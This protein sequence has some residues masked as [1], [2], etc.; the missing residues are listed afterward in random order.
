VPQHLPEEA[1]PWL[2]AVLER[3]E[4][5]WQRG[6]DPD[7]GAFLANHAGAARE[8][9][10]VELVHEDLDY[11]LRAGQTARVE[12]YL[13]RFPELG[14]RQEVLLDLLASE[15]VLREAGG[16]AV[17]PDEYRARFPALAD[18][19][20]ARVEALRS[21]AGGPSPG[22]LAIPH[23][24]PAEQPTLDATSP[25]AVGDLTQSPEAGVDS[26]AGEGPR[27]FG[28]YELLGEIARGAMGVVYKAR[29]AKLNR[30][31]ALKMILAGQLAS[32][33]E[34]RRFYTEAEA[35]ATLDHPGIVPIY[36]IAQHQGQHYFSMAFV[37]GHSLAEALRDGPLAPRAAADLVR[38][39]ALAV[40][41]A[42]DKG[43]IHRDLK[44]QNV[45]L[46]RSGQPRVTDFGLAR[47][48]GDGQLTATGAVVG[49][50]SYMPPEQAAGR[51]DVGP[52]A[53]VYALGAILYCL[54]TG[55]PPFQAATTLDTLL[56]VLEQEPVPPRRHNPQVPADLETICLAC[57]HKQPARR[58]SS[59]RALADDLGRW[60]EGRPILARPVGRLERAWK[61]ARRRPAA[62]ALAALS[63]LAPVLLLLVG[64]VYQVR[65]GQA[66][67]DLA[68]RQQDLEVAQAETAAAGD[69]ANRLLVHAG[70]LRLSALSSL[71]L[72]DNAGL[73]LLLAVEGAERGRPREAA[74]N[75]ALVAALE[76]NREVQ[77]FGT[78]GWECQSAALSED[79]RRLAVSAGM[80]LRLWDI[81]DPWS[82]RRVWKADPF[83]WHGPTPILLS[84]DGRWVARRYEGYMQS[85]YADGSKVLYTDRVVRVWDTTAGG[86]G[87]WLL[88][89]H[90]DRVSAAAFSPDGRHLLTGSWDGTARLWDLATGKTTAV[91]AGHANSLAA[92]LFTPDGRQAL[93]VS[94]RFRLISHLPDDFKPDVLDPPEYRTDASSTGTTPGSVEG[95][96]PLPEGGVFAR[97]W[98]LPGGRERVAFAWSEGRPPANP[99]RPTS[100]AFSGDGG[101]VAFGFEEGRHRAGVWEAATGRLI[102]LVDV[103]W[104]VHQVALSRDGRRLLAASPSRWQVWDV[105]AG[106]P[107]GGQQARASWSW[108]AVRPDGRQVAAAEGDFVRVWDSDTG[109]EDFELRGHQASVHFLA[110]GQDGRRVVTAGENSA[111]LWDATPNFSPLHALRLDRGSARDA[112]YSPDGKRVVASTTRKDAVL[113]DP[114][115]GTRTPLRP[116]RNLGVLPLPDEMFGEVNQVAFS[117]DGRRVLTLAA[118][119]PA[120]LSLNPSLGGL[121]RPHYAEVPH[122]PV[123][124]WDA[125][126]GKL[127][128]TLAGH[129]DR[130]KEAHFS[131]DGSRILT[132]SE[133]RDPNWRAEFMP[134]GRRTGQDA[135]PPDVMGRVWDAATGKEVAAF[136]GAPGT[137]PWSRTA[138]LSPDGTR[139]FVAGPGRVSLLDAATCRE[140]WSATTVSP[141]FTF[142]EFSDD[143]QQILAVNDS[144]VSSSWLTEGQ[145]LYSWDAAT[146]KMASTERENSHLTAAHF[147]PGTH[148]VLWALNTGRWRLADLDGGRVLLSREAHSRAVRLEFST[149]GRH[150]VTVSEDGTTRV[151]DAGSGAEVLT[152]GESPSSVR[153]A[154]FRPDGGALLTVAEDGVVR[155]VPID[156]LPVAR[157]H[158]PR[159]LTAQERER[160]GV[161]DLPAAPAE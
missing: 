53:D 98:D 81:S 24:S 137:A 5:A 144:N 146:G 122:R 82:P 69:R 124:L 45:L 94:H 113:W 125:A 105:Q 123:R 132:L 67:A 54:L 71:V 47:R 84:P 83:P 61:W 91:L 100:A 39:V 90:R 26:P 8:A 14:Q 86:R 99:F 49:T 37:E 9:L 121:L 160:Y 72:Q 55:H 57:L 159:A 3:F 56:L 148:Q 119:E 87:R 111:R 32:P 74:H 50:P 118:D 102:R 34:V 129:T 59:A 85:R 114:A 157:A 4:T 142:A 13:A 17:G 107:L 156:P 41:H 7:L 46:D 109:E 117:P 6:E 12:A 112:V 138:A 44:P 70:G 48:A 143:G 11:R 155:V 22:R 116:E 92:A 150:F 139:L 80:D 101:E 128:L 42:H 1:W 25:V 130:V 73:A 153:R 2:E 66:R 35:A 97:L 154:H 75:S 62:A 40:Q 103:E 31:V 76:Q 52:A 106:R 152:L 15:Y 141:A 20:P 68:R 78:P 18:A 51:K 27:S 29:Q 23:E 30:V 126:T 63:V 145:R 140:R 77:T 43:I 10:L 79:G 110:Y 19:M 93:T 16:E 36:E 58:Y 108:L 65:L 60:L 147:R 149:D 28:D 127:L 64:L 96:D 104:P 33:A 21:A 95:R 38:A 88:A 161:E 158:R 131:R 136:R 151:W 133:G 134:L 115:T 89:G 135:L 120:R